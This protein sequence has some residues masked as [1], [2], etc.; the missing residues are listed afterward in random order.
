MHE[1]PGGRDLWK[2]LEVAG[3]VNMA[4]GLL[5]A[6]RIVFELNEIWPL[7]PDR[8]YFRPLAFEMFLGLGATASGIGLI[9]RRSW[10]IPLATLAGAAGLVAAAM[11]VAVSGH[12]LRFIFMLFSETAREMPF[13]ITIGTRLLMIAVQ[14]MYWPILLG[15]LHIHTADSPRERRKFWIRAG[16]AGLLTGGVELLFHGIP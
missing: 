2:L 13:S 12:H 9:T 10:S 14:G 3:R 11:D 4:L 15:L 16:M 6:A 5:S 1:S 7:S 8:R